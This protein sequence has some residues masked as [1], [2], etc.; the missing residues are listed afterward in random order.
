MARQRKLAE[1]ESMFRE[2]NEGIRRGLWPGEEDHDVRFR[3]ECPDL[4]CGEPV[5]LTAAQ[6]E[7]VRRDPRRFIVAHG[8]NV[9]EIENTVERHPSCLVVEKRALGA[10]V[11]EELD[12]R[13]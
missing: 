7:Q 6:Y 4:Q 8:H 1:N 5:E 3:C 12:P 2:T 13:S 10:R 9:P 11:A